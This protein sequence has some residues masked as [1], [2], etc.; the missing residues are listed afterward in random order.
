MECPIT[1]QEPSHPVAF[2]SLESQPYELHA[3]CDWL[4]LSCRNPLTGRVACVG[5]LVPLGSDEQRRVGA[6]M[7]E[8]RSL[9]IVENQA[10][11][12]EVKEIKDDL[13]QMNATLSDLGKEIAAL[14]GEKARLEAKLNFLN[15]QY[16][17]RNKNTN[18]CLVS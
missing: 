17:K 3:L 7:L 1:L 15:D 10:F 5:D 2:A 8:R 6:E 13:D 11:R 14:L 16:L 12:N 4:E 9:T 18:M